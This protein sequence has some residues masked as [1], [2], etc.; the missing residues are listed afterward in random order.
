MRKVGPQNEPTSNLLALI[1]R[2]RPTDS[3]Y[4]YRLAS[5]F[6]SQLLAE[7]ARFEAPSAHGRATSDLAAMAYAGPGALRLPAGYRLAED[8]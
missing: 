4:R 3:A 8:V 7:R 6:A 1:E 5:A 2:R